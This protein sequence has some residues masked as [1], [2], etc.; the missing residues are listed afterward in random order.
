MHLLTTSP[1]FNIE[2]R[3]FSLLFY[4]TVCMLEGARGKEGGKE[5]RERRRGKGG[6][7]REGMVFL[8][9]RY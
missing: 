4:L 6:E 2:Y 7:G 3:T 5:E 8:N 1:S 9:S